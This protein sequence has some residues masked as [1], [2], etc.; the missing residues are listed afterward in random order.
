MKI[1]PVEAECFH[2]D[3]GTDR[4]DEAI[5]IPRNF[6][7][8]PKISDH[9]PVLLRISYNPHFAAVFVSHSR[10]SV[11]IN[12][13]CVLCEVETDFYELRR[14]IQ[15]SVCAIVLQPLPSM[16]SIIHNHNFFRRYVNYAVDSECYN[17]TK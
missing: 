13:Q 4:R 7:E 9:F 17:T 3:E 10:Q 5:V 6:A 11:V 16:A 2:A 8:T 1:L 14:L 15:T 12:V